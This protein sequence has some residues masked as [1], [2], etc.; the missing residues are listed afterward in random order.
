MI[1]KLQAL[2]AKKGFT[3]VELVVVIAIIGVL[4]AI[5]VPT[6]IG[7]VQDSNIT[8][9]NSTASTVK[10]QASAFLT[11]ADADKYSIRGT[12][13]MV[14]I[15]CTVTSSGWSVT[16]TGTVTFGPSGSTKY[17]I[18]GGSDKNT[19]F[20]LYMADVLRDFKNGYVEVYIHKAAVI[21]VAVVPGGSV[22][23]IPTT[24][25]A[26]ETVWEGT[27]EITWAGNKAG[28]SADSVIVG[29]APVIKHVA[30]AAPA[31]T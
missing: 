19:D 15:Q 18:T 22:S 7:V 30:A 26:N 17:T 3:L 14:T 25:N 21:G 1:K 13:T 8:S 28:V 20:G 9:A 11:K 6:M 5:L 31:G 23:D 16:N 4:A 24:L 27:Q 12:D 10:T 29:T 2:K